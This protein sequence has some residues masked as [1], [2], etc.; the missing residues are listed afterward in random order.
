[1][2]TPHQIFPPRM[3]LAARSPERKPRTAVAGKGCLLCCAGFA[4]PQATLLLRRNVCAMQR[5]ANPAHETH[6]KGVAH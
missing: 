6:D 5:F 2:S 4:S 3:W 1:M